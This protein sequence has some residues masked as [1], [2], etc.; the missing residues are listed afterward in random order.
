M[1]SAVSQLM[2][3]CN[4][5][6]AREH[7]LFSMLQ[8]YGA[9]IKSAMQ[10]ASTP[11]STS[12][13]AAEAVSTVDV[14]AADTGADA[15]ASADDA[16]AP[17][18]VPATQ[19]DDISMASVSGDTATERPNGAVSQSSPEKADEA[20]SRTRGQVSPS[21]GSVLTTLRS[22]SVSKSVPTPASN[23]ER[24][25][26]VQLEKEIT[27]QHARWRD[28]HAES[29]MLQLVQ[30]Q[31]LQFEGMLKAK[32]LWQPRALGSATT[33]ASTGVADAQAAIVAATAA[34]QR[35]MESVTS[36]TDAVALTQSLVQLEASL[37]A[38]VRP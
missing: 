14:S 30:Q 12:A 16:S 7:A 35:W 33:A 38:A 10:A 25:A 6:G 21:A 9:R 36:A 29:V 17:P 2:H 31:L 23:A 37:Y 34:R 28:V 8:L 22:A 1:Q 4:Q 32:A 3:A 11:V 27:A 20:H 15:T 5:G 19:P 13:P 24:E 18:P 26:A